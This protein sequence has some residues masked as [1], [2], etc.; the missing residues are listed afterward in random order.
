MDAEQNRE[1][2]PLKSIGWCNM[3]ATNVPVVTIVPDWSR[4]V[5]VDG[6][7]VF[8]WAFL[9]RWTLVRR[10][11]EGSRISHGSETDGEGG[12]RSTGTEYGFS[13]E[14]AITLSATQE[15]L[16]NRGSIHL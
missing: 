6:S 8:L 4:V 7:K 3:A 11:K 12:R 16:C 10:N 13:F 2:P 9:S 1:L 14:A 15:C 5:I